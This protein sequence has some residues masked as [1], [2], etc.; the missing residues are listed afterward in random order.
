MAKRKFKILAIDD[1]PAMLSLFKTILGGDYIMLPAT[2]CEEAKEMTG[3]EDFQVVLLD[4]GLPDGNGMDLLRYFK[5]IN[6]DVEVIVVTAHQQ[7]GLAVEA[8]KLGAFDFI[9]K[10]FEPEELKNLVTHAL[11]S[12]LRRKKIIYLES[13]MDRIVNDDFVL[14]Q[15]P[16][17]QQIY[18]IVERTARVPANILISGESG[19][20]KEIIARRI[21]HL[22]EQKE[23]PFIAVNVAAVPA[24]LIE[25]TLFG[26]EKGA[27]TGAHRLHYGKFELADGGTLFLDEIADLRIDLQAKL[28]RVL[29]EQFIE[30]VGGDRPIPVSVRIIAATNADL[31][32]KVKHG[33]FRDDLYY[34]LN[35]VRI[36]LPPLRERIED[37]PY[38]VRYFIHK[39]NQKFNRNVQDISELVFSVLSHYSWPG[40]IRELEN[41]VERLIAFSEK[42]VITEGDIPVEY[43]VSDFEALKKRSAEGD[44]LNE[45]SEAFERSFILR[46]LEKEGWNQ[47]RT[48]ERLGVHRKTLEY[49]IKKYGLGSIITQ[50]RPGARHV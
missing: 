1:D 48:S 50:R 23:S 39:Y 27:F 22:S 13:E 33:T 30:R 29:Q 41:L 9:G 16:K 6:D 11:E 28:L 7:V 26:H 45:A 42:P 35:V 21:H 14:G 44:V 34:R 17:M 25:S 37:L 8:I 38:F 49:K 46:V 2:C 19:T 20:G 32:D 43:L 47:T 10:E 5:E 40:N 24:D 15:S 12:Y 36:H 31:E 18:D 3:R 4:L